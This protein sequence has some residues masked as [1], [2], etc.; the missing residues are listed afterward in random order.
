[1]QNI[2]H[3]G[4]HFF[5]TLMLSL[6]ISVNA[7]D[8]RQQA[9][10][11]IIN[12]DAELALQLYLDIV[13]DNPD[14]A[15]ALDMAV[16]LSEAAGV[17]DLGGELLA[18]DVLRALEA[19]DRSR[20]Q[21]ALTRLSEVYAALPV[22]IEDLTSSISQITSDRCRNTRLTRSS[23]PKR[24]CCSTRGISKRQSPRLKA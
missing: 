24:R 9:E 8:A 10:E 19:D 5:A 4:L 2:R 14:D 16:L 22:E 23:Q 11:A 7:M 1:M 15:E 21:A 12:G 3:L 20:A 6:S 18:S 13:T 17:P